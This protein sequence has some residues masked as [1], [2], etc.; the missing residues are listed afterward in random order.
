MT[1]GKIELTNVN[2]KH[3]NLPLQKL[4]DSGAKI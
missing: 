4:E 2:S 1:K 3:L